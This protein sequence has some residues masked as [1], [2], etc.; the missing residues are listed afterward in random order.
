M[1]ILKRY[2]G[3][4]LNDKT[5]ESFECDLFKVGLYRPMLQPASVQRK[6]ASSKSGEFA[7]QPL[8][9]E[10][11]VQIYTMND[12]NSNNGIKGHKEAGFPK[13]WPSRFDTQ[14]KLMK[15]LGFVYYKMNEPIR[16]SQTGDYLAASVE[17]VAEDGSVSRE[18]VHPEYLPSNNGAIRSSAN[19]MTTF[20]SSCFC[21]S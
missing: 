19:S 21:R 18:V 10:E 5:I 13:G 16:F 8:T 14:F 2:D 12:P 1:H 15:A 11:A 20:R 3:K 6:W 7:D 4:E 9:D 17:I